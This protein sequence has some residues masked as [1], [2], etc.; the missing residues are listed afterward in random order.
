MLLP[1]LG[2]LQSRLLRLYLTFV[3]LSS[4]FPS[5]VLRKNRVVLSENWGVLKLGR[6]D[7]IHMSPHSDPHPIPRSFRICWS[8]LCPSLSPCSL[9]CSASLGL[10][11][12]RGPLP[13]LLSFL[14]LGAVIILPS[15]HL[16]GIYVK[17]GK[18]NKQ[19]RV[20]CVLRL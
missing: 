12:L 11:L 2:R 4:F 1:V 8:S 7:H 6:P 5:R 14:P 19:T 13:E 10:S 18:R 9:Q 17:A 20:A 15:V 3:F 16:G